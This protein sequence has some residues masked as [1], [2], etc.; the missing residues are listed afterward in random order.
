MKSAGAT[1]WWKT[2][3]HTQI[4]HTR[5]MSF[6]SDETTAQP[7]QGWTKDVH[8]LNEAAD[9]A[10][11]ASRRAAAVAKATID[12]HCAKREASMDTMRHNFHQMLQGD[13]A[14]WVRPNPKSRAAPASSYGDAFAA[15]VPV[16][17]CAHTET[18]RALTQPNR[19][20]LCRCIK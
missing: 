16:R 11:A 5:L 7:R 4:N 17:S 8:A 18:F 3:T 13:L 14:I 19:Q 12:A 20:N 6:R 1:G 2:H 15:L 9:A 10:I